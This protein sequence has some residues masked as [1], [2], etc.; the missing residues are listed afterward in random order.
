[1]R[2]LI[3]TNIVL[4]SI[5]NREPFSKV[6]QEIFLLAASKKLNAALTA[7]T[8][9]DIYYLTNK[10]LKNAG[11]S[12]DV[13]KKLFMLFDIVSVDKND[14]LKACNTGMADYEDSLLAV[15]AVKSKAIYIITRNNK[16]FVDSPVMPISP[17]EFLNK[18][19]R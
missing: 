9:S 8:I 14:C 18:F 16:D 11:Q 6:A 1:M 12:I 10:R 17:D 2:V 15:C 13:L 19:Y 4:D 5:G 3:D 7:S